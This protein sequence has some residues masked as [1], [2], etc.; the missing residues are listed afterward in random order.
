MTNWPPSSVERLAIRDPTLC[1]DRAQSYHVAF[2]GGSIRRAT[3]AMLRKRSRLRPLGRFASTV[4]RKR[5]GKTRRG[6]A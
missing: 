1:C 6:R 4:R 2:N 3:I 5:F